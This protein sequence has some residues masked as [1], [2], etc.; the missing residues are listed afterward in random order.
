M[1]YVALIDGEEREV[2]IV[3][4]SP[5]QFQIVLDDRRLEVDVQPTSASTLSCLVD[6]RSYHVEIERL[7]D[8]ANNLM[9]RGQILNVE[10]LD[11][12]K[13]RLRRAQESMEGP[14]G[15]AEI[16]APMPG[17]VV[18]VLVADGDEVVKGQGLLVV[19]AMKMENELKAPRDGVIRKLTVDEGT[20]V[21]GGTVLCVVE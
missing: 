3:E 4:I 9:V 20:A 21:E 6:D 16:T 15:P 14:G 5:G 11:L 2:E 12:R 18:A 1:H 7:P 8:G 13:Y 17:K 19:E 10:V